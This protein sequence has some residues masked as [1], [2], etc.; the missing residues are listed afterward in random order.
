MG[1][2][3]EKV[4]VATF[5]QMNKNL[6]ND[7][8]GQLKQGRPG[9]SSA[10]YRRSGRVGRCGASCRDGGHNRGGIWHFCGRVSGIHASSPKSVGDF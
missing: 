1:Q 9:L 6:E 7:L 10:H 4:R 5:Q 8:V 3:W 2:R